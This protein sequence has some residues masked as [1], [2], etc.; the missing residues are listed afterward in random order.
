MKFILIRINVLIAPM[1]GMVLLVNCRAQITAET[2]DPVTTSLVIAS[3]VLWGILVT[4]ALRTV[5]NI[6]TQL[7][8]VTK[9]MDPAKAARPVEGG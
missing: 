7:K 3:F 4:R 2:V 1:D 8:C 6:V 5:I 9:K